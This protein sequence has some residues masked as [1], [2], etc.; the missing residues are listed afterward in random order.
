MP[1]VY[2]GHNVLFGDIF[3]GLFGIDA[4]KFQN[5]GNQLEYQ[6]LRHGEHQHESAHRKKRSLCCLLRIPFRESLRQEGAERGENH[7]RESVDQD[8]RKSI[9]LRQALQGNTLGKRLHKRQETKTA[10]REAQQY[11]EQL[12]TAD[13]SS[14]PFLMSQQLP[15]AF[16]ARFQSRGK[17]LFA[18]I[19]QGG[20]ERKGCAAKP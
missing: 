6:P 8:S 16:I 9:R 7:G 12:E 15:G 5:Q 1:L 18:Q 20:S 19:L 11:R 17:F 3:P 4:A 10:D 14:R 13:E 2:H